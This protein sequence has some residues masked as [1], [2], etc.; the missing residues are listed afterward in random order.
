M[1]LITGVRK[2]I[3][4]KIPY[5]ILVCHKLWNFTTYSIKNIFR[6]F[7]R[8]AVQV[9]E[10]RKE[11]LTC[12]TENS[13]GGRALLKKCRKDFLGTVGVNDSNEKVLSNIVPNSI[14]SAPI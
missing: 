2:E 14:G 10:S 5:N 11:L 7:F 3:N 12:L 13:R 4:Y 6:Y 9:K 1:E 8:K